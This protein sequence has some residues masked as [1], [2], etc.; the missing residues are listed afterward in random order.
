AWSAYRQGRPFDEAAFLSAVEVL[1]AGAQFVVVPDVVC[2]GLASLRFSQRW[3]PRL[4]GVGRRLLPALPNALG[5]GEVRPLLSSA[6]RAFV[7]GDTA[8]KERTM[9]AWGDLAREVGC[10]L[11]VGRVNTARRIRLCQLSGAA[12]FD[13]TSVT[14]FSQTIHLLDSARRQG[15]LE[16]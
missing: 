11:H 4:R 8:W 12:S 1:G 3:L 13:G 7:G 9:P 2:G 10:Y 14:R 16:F 6:G 15:V 5:P